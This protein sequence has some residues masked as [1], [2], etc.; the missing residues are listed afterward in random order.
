VQY[1]LEGGAPVDSAPCYSVG[2]P[3]QLA[4]IQGLVGIAELLIEHG[5]DVNHLPAKGEGLT[6]FEVATEWSNVDMMSLLVSRNLN[7][8]LVV[9][10]EG[11]TQ[12]ERAMD[13]AEKRGA[14]ASKHFVQRL[15]VE[16]AVDVI[17][18]QAVMGE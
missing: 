9:D 17:N 18:L 15:R 6:A 5:A 3:L 16:S 11:H 4:A 10:E 1:L 2:T 7:F 12:Y 8:D 13:F 14:P